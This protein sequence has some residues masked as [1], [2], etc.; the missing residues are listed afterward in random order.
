VVLVDQRGTG[1]SAPLRCA[2][3]EA[4]GPLDEMYPPDRVRVCRDR[5]AVRADLTQYTTASAARDLDAVRAALGHPQI[6]LSGLSY[7]TVLGLTYLKLFP[8]RVRSAVLAGAADPAA[9]MPLGHAAAAQAALETAFA[10]CAA[11]GPCREAFPNL[12]RDWEAVLARLQAAPVR[13]RRQGKA[14]PVE[15]EIRRDVFGEA[16][17]GILGFRVWD[18]PFVVH[19]MAQGDFAPFLERLSFD[20]PSPFAEGLYLSVVCA[21]GTSRITDADAAEA[22]RG[23]FLGDYRVSQQRR[24]CALWPHARIDP[25][26]LEP[27]HS[28]V[29]ILFLNGTADYVTPPGIARRLAERLVR[30][31]VVLIENL[32]H[33]PSG[34]EPM[35]CYD[36]IVNAFFADPD[37][38][39][40]DLGCLGSMKATPFRTGPDAR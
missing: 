37:P 33:L 38:A 9:K 10:R 34:V 18:V 6:D 16:F 3:L 32:L 31:R 8:E 35:A 15:V 28:T 29:P 24:A 1:R 20:G 17:R 11:D 40:L 4:Q 39:R 19:R 22:A 13:A 12:R 25:E 7:G 2:E 30:S 21:E 36:R 23:T 26:R 27:E 14:G 5:L